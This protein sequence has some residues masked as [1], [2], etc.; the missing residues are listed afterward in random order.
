MF[1]LTATTAAAAAAAASD[2]L[3]CPHA[4]AWTMANLAFSMMEFREA[5]TSSG[6]W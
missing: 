6:N 3:K 5:Y 2:Y 1:P 4:L